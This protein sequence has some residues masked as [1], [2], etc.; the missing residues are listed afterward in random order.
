M[1]STNEHYIPR[2]LLRGFASSRKHS[3]SYTFLFRHGLEPVET[4]ITKVG[5]EFDFYTGMANRSADA[6]L[7]REQENPRER[8]DQECGY[9]R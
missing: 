2:F 4:N 7:K 3:E 1:S 6:V 8:E 5:G 9:S